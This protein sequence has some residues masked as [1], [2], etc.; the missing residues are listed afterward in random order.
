MTNEGDASHETADTRRQLE[1]RHTFEE[2]QR[3]RGKSEVITTT[4]T[5]ATPIAHTDSCSFCKKTGGKK[6][7]AQVPKLSCCE[8]EQSI[9]K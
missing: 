2:R 1:A 9:E 6:N 8:I 5:P 7:S 4:T 3:G